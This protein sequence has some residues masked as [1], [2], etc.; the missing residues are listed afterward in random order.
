MRLL[1][2]FLSYG[3]PPAETAVPFPVLF[4]PSRRYHIPN[5]DLRQGATQAGGRP[6]IAV[7]KKKQKMADQNHRSFASTKSEWEI[8]Q[9]QKLHSK[10]GS[11]IDLG[12]IELTS[13]HILFVIILLLGLFARTWEFGLLPPGL[14]QDEA[15][16]GV[17]ANSL[18]RFGV[19]RNGISYPV[20]FISWGSGQNALYAYV[21]I[22]FIAFGGLTPN[23]VRLPMLLSGILTLTLVY[24]VAMQTMNKKFALIALFLLAISPWH[25]ILSRWGLESNFLPFVFLIG[26]ACLLKSRVD[27]KWFITSCLFFALCLYTYGAAYAAIPV[28]LVCTVPVLLQAKRVSRRNLI[29]G[30]LVLAIVGAPIALFLLV[31]TLHLNPIQLSFI[32]IPRLPSQPRYETMTA[33][34]NDNLFQKV[35][36][37]LFVLIKLL[38]GQTDGLV[39][40]TVEPYGYFYRFTFPLAI[41][42]AVWL[43]CKSNRLPE[44]SL[45]LCWIVASLPIGI[46]QP[47]NINRINLIFIPLIFCIAIFLTWLEEHLKVALIVAICAFFIGFVLFTRDYHGAAYRQEA[48]KAFFMGLL[49]A[50]DFVHQASDNDNPICVTGQVDMPY[51]FALFSERMNPS[52]YLDTVKYVNPKAPLREVRSFGRYTFGLEHCPREDRSTIYI[53]SAEEQPPRQDI[54]YKVTSFN[55]YRVYVP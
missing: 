35:T 33:I 11:V 3:T 25:I 29:V 43:V 1:G 31:N 10:L 2:L 14:N 54:R 24:F 12:R 7:F 34:F 13:F 16:S 9:N 40:N 22:P 8:H 55:N 38:W 42:G 32:T 20:S 46:L 41:I 51:I 36:Q 39:W 49:P 23:M 44:Q 52:D 17:D 19:D 53:L 26:Y 30:F 21:L 50:L 4:L 37:N 18:Y 45:L 6:G 5:G 47:V 27:N 28:F 48:D 15:S